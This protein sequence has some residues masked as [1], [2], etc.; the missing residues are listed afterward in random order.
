MQGTICSECNE[1]LNLD[2]DP[3]ACDLCHPIMCRIN[4]D[5]L[6]AIDAVPAWWANALSAPDLDRTADLSARYGSGW[7][8]QPHFDDFIRDAGYRKFTDAMAY[9]ERLDAAGVATVTDES[10]A[11]CK[12]GDWDNDCGCTRLWITLHITI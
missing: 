4:G 1:N 3:V 10:T 11:W 7:D 2:R 8:N 12:R 9:L 6:A 5:D